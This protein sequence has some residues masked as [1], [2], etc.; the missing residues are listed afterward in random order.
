MKN[1][2]ALFLFGLLLFSCTPPT[3]GLFYTLA[4]ETKID[5]ASD[6]FANDLTPVGL[7]RFPSQDSSADLYAAVNGRSLLKR[8]AAGGDWVVV[9]LSGPLGSSVLSV[10]GVAS[11]GDRL[12]VTANGQLISR[13]ASGD[14]TPAALTSLGRD[15]SAAGLLPIPGL[16][17]RVGVIL[18]AVSNG[19]YNLAL[20][21]PSGPS[22]GPALITE[23]TE[24][25]LIFL[26]MA[27][28]GTRMIA[29][30]GSSALYRGTTAALNREIPAS[31]SSVLGEYQG[32][33]FTTEWLL[34]AKAGRIFSSTDEGVTWTSVFADQKK[35]ANG[36]VLDLQGLWAREGEVLVGV[37]N[38]GYRRLSTIDSV[39][40]LRSLTIGEPLASSTVRFFYEDTVDNRLYL[41][42]S[43]R[44]LWRLANGTYT[45]E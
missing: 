34:S 40:D 43:G 5:D 35:D 27:S 7:S 25:P 1:S 38:R 33:T 32:V 21:D 10:T 26:A 31:D 29:V 9:D 37:K 12:M 13:T 3:Q 16:S 28:D 42:T 36:T 20:F 4:T 15:F 39:L 19:A 45:R 24:S 11:A 17:S 22:L 6:L 30:N 44:G 41:A 2:P 18:R 8:P 23:E 14:W